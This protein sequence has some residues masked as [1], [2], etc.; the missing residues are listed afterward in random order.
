M[1]L[2][3]DEW[4]RDGDLE[5]KDSQCKRATARGAKSNRKELIKILAEL[6]FEE[7][8]GMEDQ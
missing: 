3:K 5:G 4:E 7:L 8:S 1:L 6:G 2:T